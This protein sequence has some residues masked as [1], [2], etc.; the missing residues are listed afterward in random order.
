MRGRVREG[1]PLSGLRCQ[2]LEVMRAGGKPPARANN[3]MAGFNPE[4]TKAGAE[5][6]L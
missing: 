2:G 4:V 3:L 6:S 1:Q 5:K